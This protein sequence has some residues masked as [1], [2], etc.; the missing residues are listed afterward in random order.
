[1]SKLDENNFSIE[2]ADDDLDVIESRVFR[3]QNITDIYCIPKLSLVEN[4]GTPL[5]K[6]RKLI[7]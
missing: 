1:M 5:L 6:S 4:K 7:N 3:L 2:M